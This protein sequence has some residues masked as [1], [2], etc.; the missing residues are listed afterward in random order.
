[1][2]L[3]A[4]DRLVRARVSRVDG[5]TLL[6]KL[7]DALAPVEPS[8]LDTDWDAAFAA[9]RALGVRPS[10]IVLLTAQDEPEASRGFLSAL[11]GLAAHVTVLVG[12]ATDVVTEAA[13]SLP[14]IDAEDAY[15]HAATA[16]TL[17]DARRVAS[18]IDRAGAEPVAAAPDVLPVRIADRYLALKTL[19]RL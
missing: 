9:V 12:T 14:P 2:H 18:A 5:P 6:P 3:I 4:F 16:R 1:V 13:V 8:L 19:G 17:S 10:L 11:P 7:V 15:R